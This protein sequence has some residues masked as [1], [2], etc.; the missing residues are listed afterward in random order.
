MIVRYI[1][2]FV[3]M[4]VT[5]VLGVVLDQF[6]VYDMWYPTSPI[7]HAL[8]GFVTALTLW[9]LIRLSISEQRLMQAPPILV[10]CTLI[11]GV[12]LVGIAWEWYEFILDILYHS[13]HILG[14][15][16]TLIDLTMDACGAFVY[17]SMLI[18]K[19]G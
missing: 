19:N 15:G 11:G 1:L 18:K 14:V 10:Q 3:P 17:S 7:M 6:N 2:A 12:V 9:I 16:D 4:G 13:G 5:Y 8:G